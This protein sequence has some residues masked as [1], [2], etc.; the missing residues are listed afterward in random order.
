M[1]SDH[2]S[3]NELS[4]ELTFAHLTDPHFTVPT[5]ASLA[6]IANKRALSVLSWRVKRR[7]R[8]TREVFEAVVRDASDHTDTFVLTGD[9]TQAGLD[10]ECEA[11]RDWLAHFANGRHVY[12]IPGNHD[13]IH[14]G[15]K[16]ANW[17][18][19]WAPWMG[20][21]DSRLPFVRKQGPVAFIGLSSA[22]PTA[23]FMASGRVGRAQLEALAP[24]L[25]DCR[26]QGLC[27]VLLVHHC[28]VV[29]VDSP[30][31][32]LLD[33]PELGAII[34]KHGAELILHGHNHRW[35]RHAIAG[36]AGEVDVPVLS[37]PAAGSV[38]A[39]DGRY[40]AGYYLVK[41]R[42]HEGYWRITVEAREFA[43]TAS[44]RRE[45]M[46]FSLPGADSGVL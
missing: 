18:T 1:S 42:N 6:E 39:P 2:M 17:E 45:L 13:A 46:E 24:I 44:R 35:M 10:S 29:S 7:H 12:V 25:D 19:L 36:P 38:G 33:A 21:G 20:A 14:L 5:F 41:V 8:Y 3:T 27:R 22:V 15:G 32:G 23:P 43:D 16:R 34:T 30:R 37:A 11:A 28:P 40:R 31:R 4:N 9:L 26:A